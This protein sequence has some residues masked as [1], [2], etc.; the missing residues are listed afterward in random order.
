MFDEDC[1]DDDDDVVL[2]DVLVFPLFPSLSSYSYS[3]SYSLSLSSHA[4]LVGC[5]C[6]VKQSID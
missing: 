1:Y 4:A 6:D 5:L 3:L 2:D